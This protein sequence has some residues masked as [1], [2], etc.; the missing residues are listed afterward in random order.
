MLSS[1]V[2]RATLI[3]VAAV[4]PIAAQKAKT[5]PKPAPAFSATTSVEAVLGRKGAQQPDGALKFAFPRS[6]LAVTVAGVP[7]KAGFALGSWLGFAD[8]GKGMAMVMGD[9]VL[10]EDEVENVMQMLQKGGIEQTAL[11]HHIFNENPRVLYMHIRG[12]GNPAALAAAIRDGLEQ[13][14]TPLGQPAAPSPVPIDI[15]TAGVARA[16]GYPG[17]ANGAVFQFTVPRTETIRESGRVIPVSLGIATA[18]NFQSTGGGKAAITGDFV[19]RGS[20]VNPVIRAL[21]ENG[22]QVTSLHSHL[23]DEE[24]RIYFMHFWANDDAVTLAKGLRAALDRT[25]SKKP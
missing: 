8:V 12:H 7:V 15:D 25:K 11:H 10:T 4:A 19:L 9:L 13:S 23:L 17:K 24:P 16:I 14:H 21:R 18:I 2:R 22:I 20:E 1:T 5:V 6:D 3:L